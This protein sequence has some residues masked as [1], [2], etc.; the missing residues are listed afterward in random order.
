MAKIRKSFKNYEDLS[1]ARDAAEEL[2]EI[3]GEKA[4]L[5]DI[6]NNV[7]ENEAKWEECGLCKGSGWVTNTALRTFMTCPIC[8]GT[9]H[10]RIKKKKEDKE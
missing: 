3:Y 7:K 5:G 4:V 10:T 2:V 6:L 8:K 1:Y 9:K